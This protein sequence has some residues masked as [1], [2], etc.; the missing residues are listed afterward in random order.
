[1]QLG[2]PRGECV[3]V[4]ET[5]ALCTPFAAARAGVQLVEQDIV[6]EHES[7]LSTEACDRSTLV[8]LGRRGKSIR[9]SGSSSAAFDRGQLLAWRLVT[10][11]R[12]RWRGRFTVK[13]DP[14]MCSETTEMSPP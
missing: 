9:R 13:V 6:G 14:T 3:Q 10:R 4:S 8:A 2:E 5:P 7:L 1:M 12:S 11:S